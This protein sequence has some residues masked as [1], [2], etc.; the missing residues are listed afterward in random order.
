MRKIENISTVLLHHKMPYHRNRPYHRKSAKT[1]IPCPRTD[2]RLK[3][4]AFEPN[5]TDATPK[6]NIYE[7]EFG[8]GSLH[9]Q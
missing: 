3:I 6:F 7:T 9:V 2:T 5:A 8:V 1:Q 4:Y